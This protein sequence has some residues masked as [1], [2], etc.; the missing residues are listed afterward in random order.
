MLLE[1]LTSVLG[2]LGLLSEAA[3][4]GGSSVLSPCG[5]H[6]VRGCRMH[7]GTVQAPPGRRAG[8]SEES[9]WDELGWKGVCGQKPFFPLADGEGGSER[10]ATGCRYPTRVVAKLYLSPISVPEPQSCT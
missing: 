5:G 4:A 1:P 10:G 2:P 8:G 9:L 6:S 7:G 3:G